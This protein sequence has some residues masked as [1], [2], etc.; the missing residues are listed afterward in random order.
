MNKVYSYILFLLVG[1]VLLSCSESIKT[2]KQFY[3][4]LNDPDNG[5]VKKVTVGPLDF[6]VKY[7]PAEY[8]AFDEWEQEETKE[9]SLQE[10]IEEYNNSLTFLFTIT[11]NGTGGDV[12][13]MRAG[14][15]N[16][17]E[18]SERVHEMNFNLKE[19][20]SLKVDE[21]VYKPV[22]TRLENIYGVGNYRNFHVVFAPSVE[23]SVTIRQGARYDFT[24]SDQF[25]E[26]GISHFVFKR[27]N[28]VELP[29]L[30]FITK[31]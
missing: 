28:I 10:L 3:S 6:Q 17:K 8:L 13:I 31:N 23:D 2:K 9:L 4:W 27:E 24:F 18:Y 5:L 19:Y 12:D 15:N 22:L 29:K 11:P 1:I 7:I 30:E 14:V 20:V 26:T 21:V 16:Y 25:F